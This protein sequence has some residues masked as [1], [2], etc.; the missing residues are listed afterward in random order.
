MDE[1]HMGKK[2][3]VKITE[4]GKHYMKCTTLTSS[5]VNQE[6]VR[7]SE[8]GGGPH[9]LLIISLLTLFISLLLKLYFSITT[10]CVNYNNRFYNFTIYINGL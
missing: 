9:P 10:W 7:K 2:L 3:T 4:A 1:D 6:S 8:G 5:M